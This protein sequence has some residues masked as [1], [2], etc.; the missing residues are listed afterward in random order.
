MEVN[1][2]EKTF[3]NKK[4][5]VVGNSKGLLSSGF[6]KEIDSHDVVCRINKAFKLLRPYNVLYDRHIGSRV[7]VLFV[8][9]FKRLGYRNGSPEVKLVQTSP[10]SYDDPDVTSLV[11]YI[12]E[13]NMLQSLFD[14]FAPKKPS[15]GIRVLHLL[16]NCAKPKSVDVYGF[17]WKQKNPSF[18]GLHDDWSQSE[19]D[20]KKE[21][22]YCMNNF[23]Y[24]GSIFRLHEQ[25]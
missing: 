12:P 5:A 13:R 2:L 11:S 4:V 24:E 9:L 17:D 14:E 21:Q 23:F 18:Y 1:F 15:T 19:H 20:F 10:C 8:N 16:K 7:D 25:R 6:G 3:K 22:D